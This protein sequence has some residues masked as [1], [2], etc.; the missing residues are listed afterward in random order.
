MTSYA[1]ASAVASRSSR[2]RRECWRQ[3]AQIVKSIRARLLSQPKTVPEPH[4]LL[5]DT[6]PLMVSS[7]RLTTLNSIFNYIEFSD[8]QA[9]SSSSINIITFILSYTVDRAQLRTRRTNEVK[10]KLRQV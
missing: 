4:V 3:A 8:S 1:C 2:N 10:K 5:V 7:A 9:L 6:D